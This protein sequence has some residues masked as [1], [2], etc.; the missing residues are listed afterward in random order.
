MR[1]G[2]KEGEEKGWGGD[3]KSRSMCPFEHL[4]MCI[5]LGS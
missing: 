1:E 3:R 2:E 4:T 5:S